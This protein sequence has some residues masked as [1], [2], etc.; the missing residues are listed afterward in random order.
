MTANTRILSHGFRSLLV[1]AL[2]SLAGAVAQAQEDRR[3]QQEINRAID[4]IKRDDV[5][6]RP[7]PVGKATY[8]DV[9]CQRLTKGQQIQGT[10]LKANQSGLFCRN[11]RG[12]WYVTQ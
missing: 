12:E 9:A 10:S 6:D 3:D 2:L 7:A 11:S 5:R 8:P 4:D 1:V